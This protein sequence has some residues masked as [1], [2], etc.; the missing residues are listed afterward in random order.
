MWV[1][2]EETGNFRDLP[3]L[4]HFLELLFILF[5]KLD[6]PGSVTRISFPQWEGDSWKGKNG[7]HHNEWIVR[8]IWPTIEI[9]SGTG[10]PDMIIDRN[11]LEGGTINK[12]WAKYIRD[13]DP[14]KWF[15]YMSIPC[16]PKN[17]PRITYVNRQDV[18]KRMLPPI[19]HEQFV[20]YMNSIPDIEFLDIQ[21]EKFGWDTQ[22]QVARGTDLLI[23]VHGNGMSHAAFMH[24]HR[25]V[26]EIFV[27][28]ITFEWD[29]YTLSKMMGHEYMCIFN[30][31]SCI[32]QMFTKN[33]WLRCS[34]C[35]IPTDPIEV[36]INQIKEEH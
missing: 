13:F 23:G 5:T 12:A 14:Y 15:G 30:G 35:S 7:I 29:Y 20:K 1:S 31:T 22:V 21:M 33:R 4:F 36:T 26:I 18:G 34:V 25:N 32:P 16:S 17:L 24:P 6:N 28:G 19:V 3:H 11:Y 8:N 10:I 27:P 2:F 9:G